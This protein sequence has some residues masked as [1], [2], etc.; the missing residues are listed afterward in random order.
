MAE[1]DEVAVIL[2]KYDGRLHRW[3]RARRLGEDDHGVWLAT[4]AGTTVHYNYGT[5]RTGVT[6]HDAVRLI[7]R[8]DWWIAM[9]TAAPGDREVYCDISLPPAWT[10]PAEVTV[11]DLDLDL[12][13]FRADNRVVLDDEQEFAENQRVYGY[14][15]DLVARA[16]AAAASLRAALITHTEP[17]GTRHHA[18]LHLLSEPEDP[19]SSATA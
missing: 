15:P 19:P 4:P 6:R 7:P 13:R 12:S 16:T 9:F 18:W 5:R 10:S 1:V 14:P 11:I 17:F 8:D 3:V 2:R